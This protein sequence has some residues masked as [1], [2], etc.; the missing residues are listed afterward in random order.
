MTGVRTSKLRSI[1][2][3]IGWSEITASKHLELLLMQPASN[4]HLE[5]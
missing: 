5:Q 3:G 4:G 1:R 2:S